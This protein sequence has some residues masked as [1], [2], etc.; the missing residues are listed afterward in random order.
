MATTRAKT[1]VLKDRDFKEFKNHL[2]A[3][4]HL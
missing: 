1:F 3:P 2:A 4:E